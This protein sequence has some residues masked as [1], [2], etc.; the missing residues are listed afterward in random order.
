[1]CSPRIHHALCPWTIQWTRVIVQ[2]T[3]RPIDSTGDTWSDVFG[4][5]FTL[6]N[7]SVLFHFLLHKGVACD[8]SCGC[9][10]R[11]CHSGDESHPCSTSNLRHQQSLTQSSAFRGPFWSVHGLYPCKPANHAWTC[12]N[13]CDRVC[14]HHVVSVIDSRYPRVCVEQK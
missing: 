7:G 6:D 11:H 5:A 2:S 4:G 3:Q 1:M 8:S 13:P 14:P 9:A 12:W 10:L